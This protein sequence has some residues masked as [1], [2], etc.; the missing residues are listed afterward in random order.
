[1]NNLDFSKKSLAQVFENKF[2]IGNIVSPKDFNDGNIVKYLKHHYNTITAENAMKPVY[3]STSKEDYDFS[4]SDKIVQF[5]VDNNMKMIGH[6]LI[7][8]GQSA[9]WLNRNP[10]QSVKTRQEAKANMESF[11]K[12]YVSRYAGKIYSW[13]VVNEAFRDDHEYT[14]NWR[15][16]LRKDSKNEK[17]ISHWYLAYAN[18]SSDDPSDYI[19]DAYYFARKYDPNAILYYNEYN[20]ETI[21]KRKAIINMVTDINNQWKSHK[22]YDNRDLIEGIGMQFHLNHEKDLSLVYDSL[23]EFSQTG[24][25]MAATEL[26]ITFGSEDEVAIPLTKEQNQM[27]VSMYKK[28][29]E[30]FLQF[31][32]I[33]RVTFWAKTDQQSWRSWGSPVLFNGDGS[34]KDAFDTIVNIVS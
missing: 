12:T 25:K 15:D 5:A 24:L 30:M 28:I 19:F 16:H 13:D 18:E 32:Q 26:D 29:F 21:V 17:A 8:H 31:K 22:E 14:G 34:T 7:W 10:D 9:L 11:I 3:I 1:M 27:Q 2:L 6:T 23:K 33:E 4:Q 20:E